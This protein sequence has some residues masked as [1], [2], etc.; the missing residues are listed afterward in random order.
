MGELDMKTMLVALSLAGCATLPAPKLSHDDFPRVLALS[1][2]LSDCQ[3]HAM[4]DAVSWFERVT[5]EDLFEIRL[6]PSDSLAVNGLPPYGWLAVTGD[7]RGTPEAISDTVVY[8]DERDG[9][10]HSAET[11][12]SPCPSTREARHE[13][14]HLLGLPDLIDTPGQ[15]MDR[16]HDE[17][18]MTITPAQVSAILS[19]SWSRM[20]L[21]EPKASG[22]TSYAT[23]PAR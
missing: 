18:A 13:T 21:K 8:Y 15:L 19:G 7:P 5:G 14:G 9:R 2:A 4:H 10:I 22:S 6:V 20:A 11:R 3:I 1:D 12:L 17:T 23:R 16:E